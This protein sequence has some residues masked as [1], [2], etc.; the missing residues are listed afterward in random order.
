VAH[1]YN[2][3]YLQAED[4]GIVVLSQPQQKKFDR[5]HLNRKKKKLGMVVCACHPNNSVM[6]KLGGSQSRLAW[7][8]RE[9]THPK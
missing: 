4:Q 8:K 3:S 9:T 1:A 2:P 7:V 5:P 6:L